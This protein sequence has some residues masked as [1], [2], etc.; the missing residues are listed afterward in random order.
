[1]GITSLSA[2]FT[3]QRRS[4][5]KPKEETPYQAFGGFV[6][7]ESITNDYFDRAAWRNERRLKR[8][9][10]NTLEFKANLQTSILQFENWQASGN[11]TFS[12]LA[13]AYAHH[14]FKYKRFT[15]DFTLDARYG[16]NYI[17]KINFK[18]VDLFQIK[19]VMSL[20]MSDMWSYSATFNFRTQFADGFKSRTDHTLISTI[21]APGYFDVAL[22]CTFAPANAP[23]KITLSPLS[24]NMITMLDQRLVDQGLYGVPAGERVLNKIGPSVNG[25]FDNYFFKKKLRYR[26]SLYLF[27]SYEKPIEAP[28]C[29]WENTV[30]LTVSKYISVTLY[31]LV[32]YLKTASRKPQYQYSGTIG[33]SY[34]FK[35]K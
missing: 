31:G 33:L 24:G 19:E 3:I 22:G 10:R 32:Y 13:T 11:N 30:D 1:M 26:S 27:T 6:S 7:P 14:V 9:E 4:D 21:M 2:Q 15:S 23:Y 34:Q 8:R 12:A 16:I 29:R 18:N 28:T 5:D 25:S 17:D 35:N 20:P